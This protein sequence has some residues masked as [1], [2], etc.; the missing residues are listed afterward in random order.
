M[1]VIHDKT[2]QKVFVITGWLAV[3]H[4]DTHELVAG[5]QTA[6][7]R[8]METNDGIAPECCGE[9]G[10]SAACRIESHAERR[11]VR[12]V[13][14]IGYRYLSRQIGALALQARVPRRM[15]PHE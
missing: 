4:V 6:V 5:P 14:H 3:L 9:R 8:T 15:L 13:Q 12:L 2:G 7:P 10:F 1:C 11:R